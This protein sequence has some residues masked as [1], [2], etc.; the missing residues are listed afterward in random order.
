MST[1]HRSLLALALM[2]VGL[3]AILVASI[4]DGWSALT[5]I[6]VV[7]LVVAIGAQVLALRRANTR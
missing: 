7:C 5:L 2:T 6:G 3:I 4:D 1:T